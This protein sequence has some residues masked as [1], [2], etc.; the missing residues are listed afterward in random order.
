MTQLTQN[1]LKQKNDYIN[2][3]QMEYIVIVQVKITSLY[4]LNKFENF[5][6]WLYEIFVH[7]Y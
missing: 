7:E 4:I 6:K 2:M 5:V 3:E 1:F